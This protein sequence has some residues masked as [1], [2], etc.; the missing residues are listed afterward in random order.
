MKLKWEKAERDRIGVWTRQKIFK[1]IQ[2]H[3]H[4]EINGEERNL[5]PVFLGSMPNRPFLRN[6]YIDFFLIIF[7]KPIIKRVN[8]L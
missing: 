6:A 4:S 7:L 2:A 8:L 3:I 5:R 1:A